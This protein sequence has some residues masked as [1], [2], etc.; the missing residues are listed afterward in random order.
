MDH[1]HPAKI[2][3]TPGGAGN[4]LGMSGAREMISGVNPLI[5]FRRLQQARGLTPD[6]AARLAS[7]AAD[8]IL[9]R[10]AAPGHHRRDAVTLLCELASLD[11]PVLAQI[12]VHGLFP[13]L[14]ETLGDAFTSAAC[15]VYNQLFAQVIQYCRR[16]P[17]GAAID[18]QLRHFGLMT[19]ADL[20]RRAARIRRPWHFE[21]QRAHRIR[22][23]FVLSRVTLGADI[24][25]T[26]VVLAAL[27]RVYP[28]AEIK[29]AANA[30]AL[31]LF[32]GDLRIQLCAVEY[33]RGGGLIERLTGWQRV[34]EVLRQETSELDPTEYVIVDPDSR[35]TQLGLLPLVADE[36]PYLFFESRSYCVAGLQKLGALTAHW[37][38]QVFGTAEPVYPYCAPSQPDVAA[39]KR[40]LSPLKRRATRPIV[41]V[42]LGVGAN[43]SK[44]LQDPFEYRLLARL[45]SAG[46]VVI[47]DKG[48]DA[49]EVLRIEALVATV[50][51]EGF[52]ALAL[53]ERRDVIPSA[54]E[55]G[56]TSLLTW[57]GDIGRFA[58]LTGESTAY[59]GYDSAG[60]HIAAALG[61]P[62]IDIFTGFTSPRMPQRWS[63]HGPGPVHVLVLDPTEAL[64]SARLE[65]IIDDVLAHVPRG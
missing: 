19:E 15:T 60:Q 26:S 57:Q 55:V 48:A 5:E 34:V 44:R 50:G 32:A 40:I 11:D 20:V 24:A 53:D 18:R 4:S 41:S 39:A 6:V 51:R 49:D 7:E 43:P 52:R 23:A 17:A 9:R 46:A 29:L 16:L 25:V 8:A 47:L 12:G 59:I 54:A 2:H 14:V 45:L 3:E 42:N 38:Q 13:L 61:V 31:Q 58:A 63:P 27:K 28:Q 10:G 22:K 35:L 33:P 64:S 37:L 65:A 56:G 30:K 21:R 36:R 62:T 1:V